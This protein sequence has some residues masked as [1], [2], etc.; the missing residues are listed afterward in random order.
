MDMIRGLQNQKSL[1]WLLTIAGV[2]DPAMTG[3]GLP[4]REGQQTSSVA[5]KTGRFA[6]RRRGL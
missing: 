4:E 5:F 3:V 1:A 2:S 6:Q